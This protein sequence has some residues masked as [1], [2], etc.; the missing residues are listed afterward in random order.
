[1]TNPSSPL[2]TSTSPISLP[3]NVPSLRTVNFDRTF[4]PYSNSGGPSNSTTQPSRTILDISAPHFFTI[5]RF[6]LK[7][8]MT[9]FERIPGFNQS[10]LNPLTHQR[11]CILSHSIEGTD[12]NAPGCLVTNAN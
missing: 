12:R 9:L 8:G 6:H 10:L 2:L 5:R 11:V 4:C 7:N 1:M 3:G